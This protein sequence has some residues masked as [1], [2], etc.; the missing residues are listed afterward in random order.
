MKIKTA[1]LSVSDKRGL[2]D[3]GRELVELGV[4][5]LSTGGTARA[6]REAG[7]KVTPVSEHTGFPE[8]LNG[9]V[10]TL[11]PKVH[12]GILARHDEASH[13]AALEEH[14]IPAIG[15]VA[16]NLYPFSQTVAR[17]GVTLAE[18]IEKIDIGGPTMVR[19]AAKNAR[20]VTIVVDPDDYPAIIAEL[21]V[22][23]GS[24]TPETRHTMCR[25]A[26]QHTAAYDSA[27]SSYFENLADDMDELPTSTALSLVKVAS[28]R[29]GE[30][31]HQRAA[32]YRP[33]SRSAYGL[34]QAKQHQGKQLSYNNYV[35]L[36][37]A[38]SLSRE[39]EDP[40]CAIIKHTNP[41]GAAIGNDPAEAYKK[42]L[43]TDPVSAFGSI[44]AF[45]R[46]VDAKVASELKSLF[47]EAVIAPSYEDEALEIFSR[48]KALRIMEMD[49]GQKPDPLEFKRVDGGFLIQ[50]RDSF[51]TREQDLKVVTKRKPSEDE[52]A[53]LLF[54]WK[55][56]K[57]VK[58]NAILFASNGQT[59][60]VGAGQMS[61][62]DSAMLAGS[63]ARLSTS[64]CVMASDAF[65][66]FRDG[67]DEAAK[68]GVKAVIEP[69]G[70]KRDQ[71]VIDAADEHGMAM[72][73][74]GVRHFKH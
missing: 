51:F 31:P 3:F 46:T 24:T 54:A 5:I 21:R 74:T 4:T 26:F 25:K 57:H 65:F 10:K 64:G 35:D 48:K 50:D 39:F 23:E 68:A 12:G 15:L 18:A 19:A 9:R 43:E 56:C 2:V 37:A 58:S 17:E 59:V 71:E 70:S 33:G 41:C 69:G 11:H 36:E 45:N 20:T 6:L 7:V 55:V 27:I 49:P 60:G 44:I 53:N 8:I 72:V 34:V 61:R 52:L 13:K 38:W 73:F 14:G 62:V 28:L 66:P 67:I 22:N 29:Y 1:L 42:A 32:L 30:N 40:F 47:V 63:R 16:V